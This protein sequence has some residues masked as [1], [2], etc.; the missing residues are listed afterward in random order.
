MARGAS[1]I[2]RC[3]RRYAA[4][5]G[6]GAAVEAAIATPFLALLGLGAIDG[7][8]MLL[9]NHKMEQALVSA[10]NFMA[11]AEDPRLVETQAKQ[12]AV[13]GTTNPA[14]PPRIKNWTVGDITIAYRLVANSNNAYRGGGFIRI[15]DIQTSHRYDGFGII[16]AASRGQ[17]TLTAQ[18][19]QRMTGTVL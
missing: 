17:V 12:I 4:D 9:Q 7:S 3:I 13:S 14:A 11:L 18:Y 15:V 1:I 10:A 5:T 8:Y 6:G 19:Q 16:K 2:Q